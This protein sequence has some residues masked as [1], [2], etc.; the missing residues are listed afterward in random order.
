LSDNSLFDSE[1]DRAVEN[2]VQKKTTRKWRP[3]KPKVARMWFNEANMLDPSQLCK[4]L[5]FIDMGQ[6][7]RALKSYHIII[8]RDYKYLRNEPRQV[9][10]CRQVEHCPFFMMAS[11]VGKESTVMIR[12]VIEP[13]QCGTTNDSSRISSQWLAEVFEDDIRSD[14]DWK[15]T[16]LIDRV[17]RKYGVEI[18]KQIAYR[19]QKI[20]AEKVLGNHKEQ[21]KRI[22]DYCQ[23]VVDK[24]P[25]SHVIVSTTDR[26][27]QGLIPRFFGLFMC[28]NAQIQGFLNGCKPFIGKF[29]Y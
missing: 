8:G 6:F 23:T 15:V 14:P 25:D 26:T 20:A 10:V 5:C 24:D 27:S 1:D 9:N 7:R 22:R 18:S 13:H 16:G 3:K 4:G 21:Y 19:A 2:I 29:Q 11:V 12:K 17:K 28:L